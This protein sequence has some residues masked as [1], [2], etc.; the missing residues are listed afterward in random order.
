MLPGVCRPS[1]N[2]KLGSAFK[3]GFWTDG[4]FLL[5]ALCQSSCAC[6]GIHVAL[7]QT[8]MCI[9]RLYI[10]A[11]RQ[12]SYDGAEFELKMIDLGKVF[13]VQYGRAAA[14][15]QLLDM[16][17]GKKGCWDATAKRMM[18]AFWGDH[19]RFFKSMLMASKVEALAEEARI[20]VQNDYSVVIG[21]Q[22]TGEASLQAE[23]AKQGALRD[24][25]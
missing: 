8:S 13:Q 10:V 17:V 2:L 9:I 21:L 11:C 20:S 1:Q 24:S 7:K 14:M 15:W 22:S 3:V 25:V 5:H 4:I 23:K 12:L 18:T 16:L 19:L 6:L